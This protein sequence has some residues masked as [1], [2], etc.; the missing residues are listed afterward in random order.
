[1][2]E[3]RLNREKM[4]AVLH[5]L[6]TGEGAMPSRVEG[7]TLLRATQS[8]A[9]VPVLYEPCIVLVA[10]GLKRF[11]LPEQV[12][13]YDARRYLMLTVPV[14]AECET[15]V[16]PAGPFLG[17]AIRIDLGTLS[18]LL[19]QMEPESCAGEPDGPEVRV[20]SLPLE[21]ELSD[22]A[23]ELLKTAASP[24]DAR[25]LGPQRVREVLYRVLTGR[26]GGPLQRLL[27]TD[28]SRAQVHRILQRMHLNYQRPLHVAELARESGMS[29]SALH[30]HFRAVTASSPVQYLK[31]IRLHKARMLMVQEQMGAATAAERVGY[32]SVSQFSREFKRMFGAPPA[33]EAARVRAA[34]GFTDEVSALRQA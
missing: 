13:T 24:A 34:F 28:G 7:L 26:G 14:P 5:G 15:V 30:F 16:S 8:C 22:A 10:Q 2:D 19:M 12:L 20:S 23:L 17:M 1:M 3:L 6:C 27:L 4:A 33:G 32:D 18:E 31:T 9:P 29:A 25:V 21:R 11:H